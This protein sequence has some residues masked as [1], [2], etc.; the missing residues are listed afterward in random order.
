MELPVSIH[1]LLAECDFNLDP[2]SGHIK[3]SIHALLAECDFWSQEVPTMAQSF[4]PRTPCGVRHQLVINVLMFP[5]FQSTHSLRSATAGGW[6][7]YPWSP[8]SIH[9]LL[10]E[11]DALISPDGCKGS[12]SIHALLAE[13]DNAMEKSLSMTICF[14]PRTPCGVR[15]RPAPL[16]PW[17]AVV[18][19]HAL[20]AEC[21]TSLETDL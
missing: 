1:A 17:C 2:V 3:V 7:F 20:L 5:R 19:I 6:I 12:V 13:C 16:I 10:A 15:Q 9:A 14:N 11:C 18:S 21:D 8:V 4:N